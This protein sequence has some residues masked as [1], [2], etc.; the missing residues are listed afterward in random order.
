MDRVRG[1][2]LLLS[3][4]SGAPTLTDITSAGE[5]I[6]VGARALAPLSLLIPT[7]KHKSVSCPGSRA[8]RASSFESGIE[9]EQSLVPTMAV[10]IARG[11]EDRVASGSQLIWSLAHQTLRRWYSRGLMPCRRLLEA[12]FRMGKCYQVM[13]AAWMLSVKKEEVLNKV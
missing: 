5:T 13:T 9:E 10:R 11:M 1:S 12:W 2:L 4:L 3:S 8:A 6:P 7:R